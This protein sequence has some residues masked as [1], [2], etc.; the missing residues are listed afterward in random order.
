MQKTRQIRRGETDSIM[1]RRSTHR[2]R[3]L[4]RA[5]AAVLVLAPAL[6]SAHPGHVHPGEI[7]EFDSLVSGL[8]HPLT[9]FDHLVLALALGW[10]S[11][12]LGGGRAWASAAAFLTALVAG[13]GMG[14]VLGPVPAVETAIALT[15]IAAGCGFF[16]QLRRIPSLF[17]SAV[18]GCGLIHGFAHGAEAGGVS[19][20]AYLGGFLATTAGLLAAGGVLRLLVDERRLE[21]LPRAAGAGMVLFGAVLLIHPF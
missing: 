8:L 2:P 3:A 21:P 17:L 14:R 19:F 10:L 7:D 20:A 5:A 15:V 13:A 4:I 16:V 18:C 6:A 9:G 1:T 11:G 12:A